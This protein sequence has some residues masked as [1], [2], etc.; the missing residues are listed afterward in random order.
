MNRLVTNPDFRR[1]TGQINAG[2]VSE[3]QGASIQIMAHI[4]NLVNQKIKD[5]DS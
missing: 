5:H 3:Q 1:Q 2:Y 4:R